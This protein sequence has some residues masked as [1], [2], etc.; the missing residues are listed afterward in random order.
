MGGQDHRRSRRL[1]DVADLQPDDPVLDV[2][3]DADAVAGGDLGDAFDQLDQRQ[4]LAVERDRQSA[5]EAQ[6]DRLGLDRAPA[7]G[8]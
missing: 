6:L 1:V 2:V 7:R 5:L 8:A 4:A 3:D